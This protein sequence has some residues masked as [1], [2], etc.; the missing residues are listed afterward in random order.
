MESLEAR[1]QALL[2]GDELKQLKQTW[3]KH[4]IEAGVTEADARQC[5]AEIIPVLETIESTFVRLVN[6]F[7]INDP[8]RILLETDCWSILVSDINVSIVKDS[9]GYMMAQLSRYLPPEED[10]EDE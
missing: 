9:M 6:L 7:Q 4:L 1:M 5:A 10:D 3:T 8:E 2:W